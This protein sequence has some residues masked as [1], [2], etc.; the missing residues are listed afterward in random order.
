MD[1]IYYAFDD[2]TSSVPGYDEPIYTTGNTITNTHEFATVDI[3][4]KKEWGRNTVGR[5]QPV[6]LHLKANGREIEEFTLDGT[7]DAV[8][9]E[10]WKAILKDLPLNEK[11]EAIDYT[12][13][14]DSLGSRWDYDV[15]VIPVIRDQMVTDYEI[16]VENRYNP[17]DDGGGGGTDPEDPT[18]IPD[19]E[20][21]TTELP[22]DPTDIP[23][24]P[25]DLPDE[26]VPLADVPS[27]GD[28]LI[29]WVLAAA[30]SGVGLVWLAISGKK[31]KDEQG[32]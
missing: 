32:E 30:V 29:A 28:N 19:E 31:R 18:D 6:T 27:T 24:D 3:T 25:T 1:G 8:E 26:D 23:E 14:E 15:T 17:K 10:V 13:S 21:P 4:V 12:V 9:Q 5:H 2:E 11:G 16:I 20:T 7:V 22:E